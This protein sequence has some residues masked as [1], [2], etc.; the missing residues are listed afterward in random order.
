MSDSKQ[1]D[2]AQLVEDLRRLEEIVRLLEEE[3][4]RALAYARAEDEEGARQVLEEVERRYPGTRAVKEI[5]AI[6]DEVASIG[7]ARE[8]AVVTVDDAAGR[9]DDVLAPYQFVKGDVAPALAAAPHRLETP[10]AHRA[11]DPQCRGAGRGGA[12]QRQQTDSSHSTLQASS[13]CSRGPRGF[14]AVASP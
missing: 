14:S 12:V 4:G 1:N 8:A 13:N 11:L 6:L 9:G 5:P 3:K 10:G 2:G 7:I